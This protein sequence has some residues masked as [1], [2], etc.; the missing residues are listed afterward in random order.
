MTGTREID[1]RCSE[2]RTEGTNNSNGNGEFLDRRAYA[3]GANERYLNKVWAL[4]EREA[5]R[6]R[7][8]FD[9]A[10]TCLANGVDPLAHRQVVKLERMMFIPHSGTAT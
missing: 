6:A 7:V 5:Y 10:Q 3:T 2:R 1:G 9:F 8:S 4:V